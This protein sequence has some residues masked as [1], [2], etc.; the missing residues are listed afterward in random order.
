MNTPRQKY[1]KLKIKKILTNYYDNVDIAE[2]IVKTL[3]QMKD[4]ER[5][6]TLEYHID[7][8]NNIAG[9]FFEVVNSNYNKFSYVLTTSKGREYHIKKDHITKFFNI[10]GI[11]Y[12]I[13]EL[14][15]ELI[16]RSHDT[17]WLLHDDEMYSKLADKLMI[18]MNQEHT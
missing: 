6:E 14:V 5:K 12:Q 9:S 7:K 3:E 18:E 11:S 1:K 4:N 8:W 10:T 13:V 2:Y 16:K 17:E 15:Q